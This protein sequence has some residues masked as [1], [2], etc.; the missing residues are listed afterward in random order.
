M[1]TIVTTSNTP[2]FLT[3]S[4]VPSGVFLTASS[5]VSGEWPPGKQSLLVCLYYSVRVSAPHHVGS[6]SSS[7]VIRE[8]YSHAGTGPWAR[9]PW[10]FSSV[11]SRLLYCIYPCIAC[12]TALRIGVQVLSHYCDLFPQVSSWLLFI[13]GCFNIFVVSCRIHFTADDMCKLTLVDSGHLLSWGG[14]EKTADLLLGEC[15]IV[16]CGI[17]NAMFFLSSLR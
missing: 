6:R 3:K 17:F 13:I 11:V 9:M 5:S 7:A 8:L 14:Q 2:A 4:E 1:R 12:W 10:G 16:V 15:I